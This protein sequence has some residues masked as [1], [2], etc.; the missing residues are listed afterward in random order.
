[1]RKVSSPANAEI[2]SARCATP[3]SRPCRCCAQ[4]GM[5][6]PQTRTA[7]AAATGKAGIR[8]AAFPFRQAPAFSTEAPH[9]VRH[10]S[11]CVPWRG[12]TGGESLRWPAWPIRDGRLDAPVHIRD[13]ITSLT[14]PSPRRASLR[15]MAAQKVAASEGPIS[16]PRTSRRPWPLTPIARI[17]SCSGQAAPRSRARA[18]VRASAA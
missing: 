9:L 7:T 12:V 3:S 11:G 8:R 1:M 2:G 5:T 14:P 13:L 4:R 10:A 15:R 17:S 18:A 16:S 6:A